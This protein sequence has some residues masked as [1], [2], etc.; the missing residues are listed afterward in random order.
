MTT[1][2]LSHLTD[3]A[4]LRDLAALVDKHRNTT[5]ELLAHIAEVDLRK[6]YLP[7]A[8]SSMHV[9]CTR[10]LH[11]SEDATLKRIQAARAARRFPSIFE[12]VADGRLHL[13]AVVMLAAHLT[14]ENVGELVAAAAH[15]SK[16]EIE[17]VLAQRFPRPDVPTRVQ[18]LAAPVMPLAFESHAPGHVDSGPAMSRPKI[19]PLAPQRFALQLT[20]DQSTHDKLMRAQALLRHRVP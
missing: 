15:K 7:A 13:S 9:Y 10:V 17:V 16:A 11:L 18:P 6:L 8:C 1:Y 14:D 2:S 12:A 20:M 19:A 3:Q 5:A 4:L